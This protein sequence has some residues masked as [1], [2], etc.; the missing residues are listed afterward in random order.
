MKRKALL[1][2][3]L[4]GLALAGGAQA[5]TLYEWLHGG[6]SLTN[7]AYICE[8]HWIAQKFFAASTHDLTSIKLKL[9]KNGSPGTATVSIRAVDGTTGFPTGPD[10][11][12]GTI[13]GSSITHTTWPGGWYEIDV[14]PDIVLTAGTRYAIVVAAPSGTYLV[15]CVRWLNGNSAV[16]GDGME[17]SS[18]AVASDAS[19]SEDGGASW[20]AWS[21]DSIC[22]LFELWGETCYSLT[23]SVNPTGRGTVEVTPAP[24]CIMGGKYV[25]GTVVTLEAKPK[26]GWRFLN[27]SGDKKGTANPTTVTMTKDKSVTANFERV[28]HKVSR[29]NRPT[30]PSSGKKGKRLCY[31]TGGSTDTLGHKVQYRF[32]WGDG[33]ISSWSNRTKACHAWRKPGIYYVKAQAR[34]AVKTSITSQ[35]SLAK[36]VKITP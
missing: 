13:E 4:L 14:S 23:T 17:W 33:K 29:P 7:G 12:S 15:H 30:G 25:E 34:C 6:D 3:L 36:R 5:A 11:T 35:W 8:T 26:A 24:N 31:T 18:P 32:D 22:H 21:P 27:W 1:V 19:W 20:K 9:W 10:L 28:P 16:P 2:M